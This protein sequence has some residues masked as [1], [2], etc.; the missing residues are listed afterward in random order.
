VKWCTG[1]C[2][3]LLP[4]DAYYINGEGYPNGECRQCHR[5]KAR[6]SYRRAYRNRPWFAAKER[7]R[8]RERYAARVA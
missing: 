8:S 7:R 2:G 4:R 6:D 1:F 3:R 5:V